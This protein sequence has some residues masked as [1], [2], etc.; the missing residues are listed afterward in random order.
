MHAARPLLSYFLCRL[1]FLVTCVRGDFTCVC[2]GSGLLS[3]VE[4]AKDEAEQ[5]W[6]RIAHCLAYAIVAVLQT[7]MPAKIIYLHR[8]SQC[9]IAL[10]TKQ[11]MHKLCLNISQGTVQ[12]AATYVQKSVRSFVASRPTPWCEQVARKSDRYH[13]QRCS[14]AC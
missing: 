1:S 7:P 14:H 6:I 12:S 4:Q 5:V 11:K 8:H 3:S 9:S 2:T 13:V 10:G